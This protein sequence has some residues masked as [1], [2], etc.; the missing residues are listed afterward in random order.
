M[1]K[2]PIKRENIEIAI[3]YKEGGIGYAVFA[4]G[5]FQDLQNIRKGQRGGFDRY[6]EAR[7]SAVEIAGQ[8]AIDEIDFAIAKLNG[9]KSDIQK[10]MNKNHA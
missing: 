4:R 7:S 8:S 1:R 5:V 9:L 3:S 6:S 2:K 10:E